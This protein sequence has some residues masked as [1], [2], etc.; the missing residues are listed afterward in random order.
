MNILVD[1]IKCS[2]ITRQMTAVQHTL[3]VLNSSVNSHTSAKKIGINSNI[4]KSKSSSIGDA[5]MKGD[6]SEHQLSMKSFK[7]SSFDGKGAINV[8]MNNQGFRKSGGSKHLV[9]MTDKLDDITDADQQ[10]MDRRNS[11]ADLYD[12]TLS[13]SLD[14]CFAEYY[15]TCK[16][17]EEAVAKPFV[18]TKRASLLA[19]TI[20]QAGS[21]DASA[22]VGSRSS[23]IRMPGGESFNSA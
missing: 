16:S 5:F 11:G 15:D 18:T 20:R 22:D 6:V 8:S 21:K 19:G 14:S 9:Y 4:S 1:S 17:N 23:S 13:H 12:I 2:R 7:S 10:A 3:D